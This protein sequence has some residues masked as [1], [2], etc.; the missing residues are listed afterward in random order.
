MS[1]EKMIAE[2]KRQINE[3]LDKYEEPTGDV[4][5]AMAAGMLVVLSA[6]KMKDGPTIGIQ[7]VMMH[8][9]LREVGEERGWGVSKQT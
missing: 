3:T 1:S 2:F 8:K 4:K 7:I 9:A 5:C 6:L